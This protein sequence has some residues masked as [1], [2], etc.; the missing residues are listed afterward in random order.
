M[1]K[2]SLKKF[3]IVVSSVLSAVLLVNVVVSYR[4]GEV[5]SSFFDT[6]ERHD[7]PIVVSLHQLWSH[8]LQ[9]EQATRNIILNPGDQ[10]A[11]KNYSAADMEF[12]ASL[13]NLQKI[14]GSTISFAR[15]VADLWEKAN[16]FRVK[17]QQMAKNGNQNEAVNLINKDETPL[18]RE[19][20][21]KITEAIKLESSQI[22]QSIDEKHT[23]IDSSGLIS[24]SM[25]VALLLLVNIFLLLIWRRVGKPTR[26]VSSYVMAVSQGDYSRS[27][28][29]TGYSAEFAVMAGHVAYMTETLKEK[30]SMSQGVLQGIATPFAIIGDDGIVQSMTVA[31]LAAFGRSGKVADYVG[32]HISEFAYRDPKKASRAM[33]VLRTSEP[34]SRE[35][36]VP[37]D[38][39]TVRVLVSN[40]SPIKDLS[41]KII[42]VAASYLDVTEIKARERVIIEQNEILAAAASNSDA[43]SENVLS[44]VHELSD[45]VELARQGAEQQSGL[46]GNASSSVGQ[47]NATVLEVARSASK[48]TKVADEAREKAQQGAGVVGQ[49]V[50]GISKVQAQ[51]LALK[52]GMMEL[53]HK[54]QGI[55]QIMT[56]ISDIADQ[57]NLLALNAAIEAARAGDAGRGFA[58]VADEVRKLAEKTMNATHEVEKAILGIQNEAKQNIEN[59]DIAAN[60]IDKATQ[61]ANSSGN[62]LKEI[63]SLVD[64]TSEQVCSIAAASEEQSTASEHIMHSIENVNRICEETAMAMQKSSHSVISLA[65]QAENLKTIISKMRKLS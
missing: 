54:A 33:D 37:A 53:G 15:T 20:K 6:V 65:D 1:Q 17:A 19:I 56:V 50:D 59:V 39:G 22:K 16:E 10:S 47:M 61:L 14:D 26:E 42:G 34:I 60:A 58:V 40:L 36:E 29:T 28:D 24:L 44:R 2:I 32:R 51:A 52:T 55:G 31:T 12:R 62:A 64:C 57:T 7:F 48:A 49:V 21:G 3:F 18:W 13:A 46:M 27:L 23:T 63:V 11:W 25:A 41:G 4:V 5:S 8:G 43:I 35:F 38:D 9:A 45:F 30:L